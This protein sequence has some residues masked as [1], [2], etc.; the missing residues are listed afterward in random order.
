MG[1][2]REYWVYCMILAPIFYLIFTKVLHPYIKC[3]QLL[4]NIPKSY[5]VFSLPFKP[6]GLAIIQDFQH[7]TKQYKDCIY[8]RKT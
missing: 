5:K 6:L 8:K 4:N 3:K 7:Q 2:L 1:F